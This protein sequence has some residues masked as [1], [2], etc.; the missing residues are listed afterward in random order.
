MR[1]HNV[2]WRMGVQSRSP[3]RAR[4]VLWTSANTA[5]PRSSVDLPSSSDSSLTAQHQEWTLWT[6][7]SNLSSTYVV[8]SQSTRSHLSKRTKVIAHRTGETWLPRYGK[9][10]WGSWRNQRSPCGLRMRLLVR[11]YCVVVFLQIVIS[12]MNQ[13]NVSRLEWSQKVIFDSVEQCSLRHL[14]I[15]ISP[16]WKLSLTHRGTLLYVLR[17]TARK[18]TSAWVSRRE[19]TALISVSL[20][21]VMHLY[22]FTMPRRR[23]IAGLYKVSIYIYL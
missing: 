14:T 12:D 6:T 11:T 19:Q 18:H 23:I 13:A 10:D 9:A 16:P 22:K 5:P 3:T 20:V 4:V 15:P 2:V 17:I 8:R 21:I 1:G 7:K